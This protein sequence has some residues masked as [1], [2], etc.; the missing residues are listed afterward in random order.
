MRD[1][2]QIPFPKIEIIP[3]VDKIVSVGLWVGKLITQ[4]IQHEAPSDHFRED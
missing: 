1:K 4:H 2:E 3:I